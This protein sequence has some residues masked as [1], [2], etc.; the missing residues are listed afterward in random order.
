MDATS[1]PG[2]G[3]S[4]VNC[5]GCC[6]GLRCYRGLD[7]KA[8]GRVGETCSPCA[9]PLSCVAGECK[10][11]IVELCNNLDD[12]NDGAVD[13]GCD[14]DA[15]GWCDATM[16][17][18]GSPT[19]CRKGG[20]DCED[21]MGLVH[22]GAAEICNGRD[23]NCNKEIDEGNVCEGQDPKVSLRPAHL[24]S[25]SGQSSC[26]GHG[27]K[28]FCFGG[29][30]APA[31]MDEIVAFDPVSNGV[32][33][34]QA[35]LSTPRRE[36]ACVASTAPAG[37]IYC[38]G[39][40]WQENRCIEYAP[41]GCIRA[42]SYVHYFDEISR[43]DVASDTLSI[44][45]ARLPKKIQGLACAEDTSTH[46]IYCFGGAMPGPTATNAIIEYDPAQDSA[47]LMQATLPS[48][49]SGLSCAT[50]SSTHLIY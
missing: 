32:Q 35:K 31:A 39:G 20:G 49:R 3:C 13:E 21:G 46:K 28:L 34:M 50:D 40:Y 27:S 33:T 1:L 23:D 30:R 6:I 25:V 26:V 38:F 7:Q 5:E 8:C 15:D 12:D 47:R 2:I 45:T 14:D 41:H 4:A 43:Y 18:V 19:T 10:E 17:V 36:L 44:K 24:P 22:P 48:E 16:K 37:G 42:Q 11:G 29:M 9:T